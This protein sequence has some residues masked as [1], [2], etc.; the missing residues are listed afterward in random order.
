MDAPTW[1]RSDMSEKEKIW[2]GDQ[3][4]AFQVQEKVVDDLKC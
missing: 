3:G 2:K 4:I 1:A